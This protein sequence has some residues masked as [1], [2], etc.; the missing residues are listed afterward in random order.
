MEEGEKN[1]RLR[2]D[3]FAGRTRKR[4]GEEGPNSTVLGSWVSVSISRSITD[5]R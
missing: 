3:F 1:R 4:C 2:E 5:V